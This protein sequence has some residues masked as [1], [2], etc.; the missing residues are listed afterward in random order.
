MPSQDTKTVKAATTSS[1]LDVKN[2]VFFI[3][4]ALAAFG[5]IQ[6]GS[7]SQEPIM[8]ELKTISGEL[9]EIKDEVGSNRERIII[10]EQ[11]LKYIRSSK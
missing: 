10:L 5:G 11:E 9:K 8:Q 3:S 1:P 6:V 4:T 7:P 2:I